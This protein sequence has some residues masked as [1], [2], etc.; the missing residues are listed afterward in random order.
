MKSPI[1]QPTRYTCPKCGAG[2]NQAMLACPHCG[3]APQEPQRKKFR[4]PIWL[5]PIWLVPIWLVPIW[6]GI[7]IF[8]V[9]AI[10]VLGMCL[11]A[12]LAYF[13]PI[14]S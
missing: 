12:T 7:V 5:V 14:N 3:A 13:A 1:P 8:A 10:A 9:G 4:I 11:A 6:L 2:W